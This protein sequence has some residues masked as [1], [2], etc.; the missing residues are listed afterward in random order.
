MFWFCL[1]ENSSYRSCTCNH[2]HQE[3]VKSSTSFFSFTFF[4][5][6]CGSLINSDRKN[7]PSFTLRRRSSSLLYSQRQTPSSFQTTHNSKYS[8]LCVLVYITF[9]HYLFLHSFYYLFFEPTLLSPRKV[10][11]R[12]KRL[13]LFSKPRWPILATLASSY[14]RTPL[15]H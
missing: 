1:C 6:V 11:F 9:L 2:H 12:R 3:R 8:Q 7:P 4:G 14:V 5:Y 10:H 15:L 13:K